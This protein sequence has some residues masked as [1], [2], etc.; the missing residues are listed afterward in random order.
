MQN[1]GSTNFFKL[2]HCILYHELNIAK[3]YN[4]QIKA[5]AEHYDDTWSNHGLAPKFKEDSTT[6]NLHLHIDLLLKF[7]NKIFLSFHIPF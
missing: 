3:H 4:K 1:S 6:W 2:Y 7:I 5:V